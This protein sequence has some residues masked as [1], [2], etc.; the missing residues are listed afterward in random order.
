M[1][2]NARAGFKPAA[3]FSFWERQSMS[4]S[5]D[6]SRRVTVVVA[7]AAA[8][9]AG[10]LLRAAVARADE[11]Q[12]VV[13]LPADHYGPGHGWHA[14]IIV[15]VPVPK[16][17]PAPDQVPAFEKELK[18]DEAVSRALDNNASVAAALNEVEARHGE[19]A[20]AIVRQNPELT[21]DVENFAGTKSKQGAAETT[22]SLAQT[23]EL[24]DKRLFRLR[25]A[26]LDASLAVWDYEAARMQVGAATARTFI[27]VLT[28]Q[29]RLKV[30]QEF[31]DIADKTRD[32][33][34]LRVKGGKVSPIELDRAI[35][36]AAR[37]KALAKT[38]KVRVDAAK[39]RLS[40]YWGAEVVDF[41]RAVGRL[42]KRNGVP[43]LSTLKQAIEINPSLAR[44]SD[45]IG[46][47]LAQLDVE[48]SKTVPDVKVGAG[49]RHFAEDDAV[50]AVAS[51]S[52][53]L[54]VFD[55]NIGNIAAA[56]SRIAK[57]ER[58]R[59]AARNEL[60]GGLTDALGALEV[61]AA[62]VAAF[63]NDVLPPAQSA[64]ER[65]KIGYA[66]GKFD[67]LNVLDSQRSVFEARLDLLTARADYEKARVTLEALAG[68]DLGGL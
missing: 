43:T 18:L 63:E 52:L 62:Q 34:D 30:L 2:R 67:I 57:A 8:M 40:L 68:R 23:L 19:A 21:I 28:A 1:S 10:L 31:V 12:T 44:W 20:Q 56:G 35:V 48:V 24:G 3:R 46:R 11:P 6:N 54:P 9:T 65:T 33:V 66:E 61:A 36:A 22:F 27:D 42:G 58:D 55:R 41:G 45:E 59:E 32:S 64:F 29:D 39:R 50:A 60:L 14:D 38:E 4:G 49:I 26:Q 5:R 37:A 7:V 13:P 16:V 47:R 15:D 53:P 51:V 17:L 25:A